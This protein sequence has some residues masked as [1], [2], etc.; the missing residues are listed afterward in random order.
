[1]VIISRK[2]TGKVFDQC[3]APVEVRSRKLGTARTQFD[4]ILCSILLLIEIFQ[5]SFR[6]SEDL[7]DDLFF[8]Q[9]DNLS[10][11]MLLHLNGPLVNSLILVWDTIF[12]FILFN[13]IISKV[14]ISVIKKRDIQQTSQ[15]CNQNIRS[16]EVFGFFF[17]IYITNISEGIYIYIC[18]TILPTL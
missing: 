5:I 11:I 17:L 2:A 9:C 3:H 15:V 16:S 18:A 4:W 14:E 1:M 7:L 12:S 8:E 10:Y 13:I 6:F